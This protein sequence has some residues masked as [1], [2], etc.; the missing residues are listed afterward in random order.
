MKTSLSLSRLSIQFAL[1]MSLVVMALFSSSCVHEFPEHGE[2][3]R[4]VIVKF[5]HDLNWTQHEIYATRAG[6]P[7]ALA[8]YH[9]MA[10]PAGTSLAPVAEFEFTRD[11][12]ERDDFEHTF[13]LP[14]GKFDL[15]AWSDQAFT[16]NS[17]SMF[18]DSSD[19]TAI[20]YV[21]PYNGNNHLRDAF[22]GVTTVEVKTSPYA[23]YREYAEIK[24]ERPLASYEFRA[25][26]IMEF[27][28]RETS[29]G[30]LTRITEP[31]DRPPLD[32]SQRLPEITQYKV[33]MIYTGYMPSTF[34]NILNRPVNS[35]VGIS[36][37]AQID[38]LSDEEARL[39]FDHVMVNG[40]ESSIPVAMEIYAPDGTLIGRTNPIDVPTKR[41]RNTIVRG[42]FLTSQA[43]GGVGVNPDF[44]G[45][46]NIEIQ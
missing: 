18:F 36:Y 38:V 34:N 37:D 9:V 27:I 4:E 21:E 12:L 19:F 43:S 11:D 30:R 29:R 44:E 17:Q 31:E 32:I 16:H 3:R 42:R 22:R 25:T 24:M 40:V 7:E 28:D 41:A 23:D 33:K 1:G 39:G 8:R 5:T 14:E 35:S 10:F 20:S 45:E 46:Y 2:P 15:Y 13:R 26:D 6:G